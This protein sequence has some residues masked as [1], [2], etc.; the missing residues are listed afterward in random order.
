MLLLT[1]LWTQLG[2]SQHR[3]TWSPPPGMTG[4]PSA[5]LYPSSMLTFCCTLGIW[6]DQSGVVYIFVS[7]GIASTQVVLGVCL[8]CHIVE[9]P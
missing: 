8:V 5:E 7:L 2:C 4:P 1:P 9:R 6:A 3:A